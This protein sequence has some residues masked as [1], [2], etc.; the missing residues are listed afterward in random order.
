MQ[1]G[2]SFIEPPHHFCLWMVPGRQPFPFLVI[3]PLYLLKGQKI[4]VRHAADGRAQD[5]DQRY[6]IVL[7]VDDPEEVDQIN[8]FLPPIKMFFSVRDIGDVVA[9]KSIKIDLCL[10]Q[11]PED[12]SNVAWVE[13]TLASIAIHDRRA[14]EKLLLQPAGKRFRLRPG[15]SL[16]IELFVVFSRPDEAKL[17]P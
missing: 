15:R 14:W 10:G 7:V 1:F 9:A 2:Q 5:S 17:R 12:Q 16:H 13:R 8:D 4:T 3:Q 11:L 6:R